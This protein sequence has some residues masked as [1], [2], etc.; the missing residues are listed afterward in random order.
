MVTVVKKVKVKAPK[1]KTVAAASSTTDD[2]LEQ[3]P[4][5]GRQ[6]RDSRR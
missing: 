5:D 6:L 2:E 4:V 1:V 3:R